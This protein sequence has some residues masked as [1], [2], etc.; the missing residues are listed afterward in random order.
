[1]LIGSYRSFPCVAPI[2]DD[3]V[4]P[5]QYLPERIQR[6]DVQNLLRKVAVRASSAYSLK[7]PNTM[8]CRIMVRLRDG[9]TLIKEKKDYE[10]FHSRPMTWRTVAD[11]FERL[12]SAF[13]D[14]A[15]RKEIVDAVARLESI[16]IVD[17][18]K[19]LTQ[20]RVAHT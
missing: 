1:M 3:Q 9:R 19:L 2:L 8:P 7:F 13:V 14:A 16:Q 11:K 4:M 12:S 5:E 10:G 17:L 15:L 18:T 6:S 20:V